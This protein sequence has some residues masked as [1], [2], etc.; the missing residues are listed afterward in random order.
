MIKPSSKKARKL[1]DTD[2]KKHRG[3]VHPKAVLTFKPAFSLRIPKENTLKQ[4]GTLTDDSSYSAYAWA[5][6]RRNRFYQAL[7]DK[8]LPEFRISDWG[9]RRAPDE[10]AAFGLIR[11]K[12]YKEKFTEGVPVQWIG[13][14]DFFNEIGK[15][16]P[17]SKQT[18]KNLE[19]PS[20]QVAI[21]FDIGPIHGPGTPA[22]DIQIKLAKKA[23]DD[24]YKKSGFSEGKRVNAPS[25]SLLRALLRIADLLSDPIEPSVAKEQRLAGQ[26]Y[27]SRRI[28]SVRP[29]DRVA[30]LE[31]PSEIG[32]KEVA[33]LLPEFDLQRKKAERLTEKQQVQRASELAVKA[34]KAIYQWHC[35]S[36]LQFD[37]WEK[38]LK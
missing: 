38:E 19:Y 28:V 5:F 1:Q 23:L 22:I 11:L 35:L 31:H 18:H 34:W 33:K 24:L 8:S 17:S 30:I 12:N 4:Y 37:D 20:S 32:I 26:P 36:W 29:S 9:Y 2:L 13:I 7:V 14:H 25:K 15:Q 6:V 3:S 27:I 16:L 21:N 10:E